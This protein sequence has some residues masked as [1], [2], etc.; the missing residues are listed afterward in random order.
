M[1]THSSIV[2][3][4][5]LWTEEPCG[6]QS[7]GSQR[8][9]HDRATSLTHSLTAAAAAAAA[10]AKSRQS[11]LTLCDPTDGSPPGSSVHGVFQ[12]IVPEWVAISFSRGSSQPRAQT[13]VSH[14]VDR[15]FTV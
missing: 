4:R 10:A 15:R 9:G 13:G 5:I 8:V 1:A 14:I 3:W 6:L 7:T 11:C 12:A 2:A